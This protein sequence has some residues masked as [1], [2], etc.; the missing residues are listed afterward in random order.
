MNLWTIKKSNIFMIV[1]STICGVLLGFLGAVKLANF[2]EGL[3]YISTTTVTQHQDVVSKIENSGE[4]ISSFSAASGKLFSGKPKFQFPIK[5]IKFGKGI[6]PKKSNAMS[7]GNLKQDKF[8]YKCDKWSVVTTIFDPSESII[9]QANLGEDWCLVIVGDRKTPKEYKVNGSSKVAYLDADY[10]ESYLNQKFPDFM[11]K[12]PWNSFGRKNVGYLFAIDH[13]AKYVWDFDDDNLLLT[14]T[15]PF[16]LNSEKYRIQI[17]RS[18]NSTTYNPY[19]GLGALVGRNTPVWPRGFSLV[20]IKDSESYRKEFV[21]GNI[22]SSKMGVV[23]S[24]ANHDPD[25]DA[26]FRIILKTPFDFSTKILTSLPVAVPHNSLSPMNA[27]ACLFF[28]NSL[29]MLLLPVSVHGRVA[30]IWRSYIGLRLLKEVGI[31]AIFTPPMVAQFRNAHNYL[32]DLQ[33]EIPLYEKA[34]AI[35]EDLS[36]HRLTSS[37]FP[38]MIEEMFI[39]MYERDYI[40]IDDVYL[41]QEWIQA[42]LNVNYPFPTVKK[43]FGTDYMADFRC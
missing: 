17:P 29:W 25:V 26:L 3:F 43:T 30:D 23:Q 24:L 28:E 2:N 11:K 19:P 10:Q 14:D 9:K 33:S 35:V 42:L 34:T 1:I 13:G 38:G 41:A 40:S 8:N 32:A 7:K 36:K 15:F 31:V 5:D 12:I 4:D 16:S 22:P 20:H 37:S 21:C 6:I 27:Q 18:S 39:Y